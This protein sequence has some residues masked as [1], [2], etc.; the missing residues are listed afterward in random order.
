MEDWS[1]DVSALASVE[2]ATVLREHSS[3]LSNDTSDLDE[4]IQMNL[5]E[6][7]KLV[8]N[9]QVTDACIDS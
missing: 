5:S 2:D 4:C 1:L 8:L 6:V 3:S 7:S 9:W